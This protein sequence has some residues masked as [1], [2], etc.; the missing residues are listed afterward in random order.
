MH[1][2]SD[3]FIILLD[4]LFPYQLMFYENVSLS[5]KDYWGMVVV[6][7]TKSNDNFCT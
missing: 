5:V 7:N 4:L 2:V 3:S 6:L 1:G